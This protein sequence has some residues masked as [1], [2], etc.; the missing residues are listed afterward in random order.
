VPSP[1]EPPQ[2]QEVGELTEQQRR[3]LAAFEQSREQRT[4][5]SWSNQGARPYG[6]RS[7]AALVRLAA[8]YDQRAM[9]AEQAAAAAALKAKEMDERLEA[10]RTAGA[11]RGHAAA[12]DVAVVLDEADRHL[13]AA[14][15]HQ[16][17][18]DAVRAELT[19]IDTAL[20]ALDAHSG[21]SRLELRM[22]GTSRK[23]HRQLTDRYRAD[24]ARQTT[25][26]F[27]ADAAARDGADTAWRAVRTSPAAQLLQHQVAGQPPRDVE[28]TAHR[29]A[30]ARR[31]LP[32]LARRIDR[33]DLEDVARLHGS[34]TRS[35]QDAAGHRTNAAAV[36]S[37]QQLRATIAARHPE[38]HDAEGQARRAHIAKQRAQREQQAR[39]AAARQGRRYEPPAPKR[40]GPSMG[41]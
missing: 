10:E 8:D 11:T 27:Q 3:Q 4:V 13:A 18:A 15:V 12:A 32:E 41:R 7:D 16:E 5:P 6:R 20:T 37:E 40:G 29:L 22:A 30:A 9:L 1:A 25:A 24:Q 31:T 38:L 36:R 2:Q 23:E 28:E 39:E 21:K 14:R 34:A 17:R 35:A 26:L 19:R 33:T